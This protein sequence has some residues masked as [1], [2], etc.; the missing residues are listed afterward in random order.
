[1]STLLEFSM[2]P[3]GQG[4]SV[5][6]QVARSLDIIDKSGVPYRLNAMGTVMEGDYD[7]LM[8]VVKQCFERMARD[9]NR[10]ACTL[11]FDYR[12]GATGR[13]TGKVTRVEEQLGRTLNK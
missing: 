4:E 3:I 13:L 11:K 9:C 12:R 8:A 6:E 7:E 10:I 1:V 5:S 2:W